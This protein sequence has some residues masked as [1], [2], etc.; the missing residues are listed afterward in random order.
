MVCSAAVVVVVIGGGGG[1]VVIIVVDVADAAAAAA[2]AAVVVVGGSGAVKEFE[3]GGGSS[4]NVG[5]S[6]VG[7]RGGGWVTLFVKVLVLERCNTP[8]KQSSPARSFSGIQVWRIISCDNVRGAVPSSF[9]TE[10]VSLL[11]LVVL[12]L[13][14]S[15]ED[16]EPALSPYQSANN[17]I[18]PTTSKARQVKCTNEERRRWRRCSSM[19]V[20]SCVLNNLLASSLLSSSLASSYTVYKRCNRI[21]AA[22]VCRWWGGNVWRCSKMEDG[23]ASR[24]A[25]GV[26]GVVVAGALFWVEMAVVVGELV[27]EVVVVVVVVVPFLLVWNGKTE[28]TLTV[29][30]C[31]VFRSHEIK[32]QR[33]N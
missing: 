17:T 9:L 22:S 19:V 33:T 8:N 20:T 27:G 23:D 2:A 14:L 32:C 12:L 29:R 30:R 10:L 21:S 1:V 24:H 15:T 3:E 6:G 28:V 4:G 18:C 7:G 31:I 13:F 16:V 11:V 26:V 5:G 25:V